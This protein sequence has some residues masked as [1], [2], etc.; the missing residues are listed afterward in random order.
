MQHISHQFD[1]DLEHLFANLMHLGGLIES[2]CS[3]ISH[4]LA[5]SEDFL[6]KREERSNTE[7]SAIAQFIQFDCERVLALR[8]PKASDL[9]FIKMVMTVSSE[10]LRVNSSAKKV[11]K[12]AKEGHHQKH[13]SLLTPVFLIGQSTLTQTLTAVVRKNTDDLFQLPQ[14]EVLLEAACIKL[15]QL[16][17][18]MMIEEPQSLPEHIQLLKALHAVNKI[19]RRCV[20]IAESAMYFLTGDRNLIQHRQYETRLAS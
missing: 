17:L 5:D 18:E 11:Y 10:L 3:A 7:I 19:G 13:I 2:K 20:N 12:L 9:R 14:Q 1:Y 8:Q 16:I 6:E 4:L 15:E